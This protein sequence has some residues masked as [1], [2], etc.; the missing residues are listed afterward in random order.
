[1][2]R[3]SINDPTPHKNYAEG[4]VVVRFKDGMSEEAILQLLQSLNLAKIDNIARRNVYLVAVPIGKEAG[5]VEK[6]QVMD[7]VKSACLEY[8]Y[9]IC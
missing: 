6:F 9:E 3:P 8:L 2:L 5:W 7:V 1:M 4:K